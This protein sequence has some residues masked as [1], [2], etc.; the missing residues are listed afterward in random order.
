[1]TETA[2][3]G[4]KPIYKMKPEK[5]IYVKMRDGIRSAVDIYR[6]DAK[7]KFPALLS[8]SPYSKDVQMLELPRGYGMNYEWANIEAGDTEFWV[9]RGS[10]VIISS[11][12]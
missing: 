6:P 2:K 9:S 11:P 3:E 8:M 1:M 4:S 5:D 12:T 10:L 7:G